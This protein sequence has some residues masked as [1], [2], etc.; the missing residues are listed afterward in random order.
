MSDEHG[1]Q[2]PHSNSQRAKL[3]DYSFNSNNEKLKK[4]ISV[5]NV[6][7]KVKHFLF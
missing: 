6:P 3:N 4:T 5:S 2:Q 1:L 7:Y